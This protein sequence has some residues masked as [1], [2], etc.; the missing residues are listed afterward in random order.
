MPTDDL[1][2][3]HEPD[4]MQALAFETFHASVDVWLGFTLDGSAEKRLKTGAGFVLS[5]PPPPVV[6]VIVT[7]DVAV[8]PPELE[9]AST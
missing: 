5:P 8:A 6:M 7:V 3:V 1:E 2:P 9:H 4:A